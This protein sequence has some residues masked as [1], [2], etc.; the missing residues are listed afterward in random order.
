MPLSHRARVLSAT[1]NNAPAEDVLRFVSPK[2]FSLVL[3]SAFAAYSSRA[4]PDGLNGVSALS[5]KSKM[6]R[7]ASR[8][9]QSARP[10][11]EKPPALF[12]RVAGVMGDIVS[13][14]G[15]VEEARRPSVFA[16]TF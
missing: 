16:G 10:Q 5:K 8:W 12:A 9:K 1:Q 13:V 15:R 2:C 7:P 14:L 3:R 4:A 11:K 6:A